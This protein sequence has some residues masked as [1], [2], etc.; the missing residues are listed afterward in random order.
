MQTYVCLSHLFSGPAAHHL[1]NIS[2]KRKKIGQ[3]VVAGALEAF[4][5]FC[6]FPQKFNGTQAPI[7]NALPGPFWTRTACL[8]GGKLELKNKYCLFTYDKDK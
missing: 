7:K 4:C 2:L 5:K 6:I 3:H 1:P 8:P